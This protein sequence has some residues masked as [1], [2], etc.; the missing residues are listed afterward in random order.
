MGRWQVPLHTADELFVVKDDISAAVRAQLS[1]R[2]ARF[3]FEIVAT[4]VN[5]IALDGEVRAAISHAATQA[6]LR[7]AATDEAEAKKVKSVAWAEADAAATTVGAQADAVARELHGEGMARQHVAILSGMAGMANE[8]TGSIDGADATEA[9][10][11]MV[12]VQRLEMLTKTGEG[13]RTNALYLNH[14]VQSVG[15]IFRGVSGS[16]AIGEGV[17]PQAPTLAQIVRAYQAHQE[18]QPTGLMGTLQ[19]WVTPRG[20]SML[21]TPL[22]TPT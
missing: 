16:A 11:M 4:L 17:A 8:I 1:E 22:P 7:L 15:Q 20:L 9:L 19:R 18:A 2:A 6:R 3:G 10:R 21:G 12:M 13:S 5:D 14:S